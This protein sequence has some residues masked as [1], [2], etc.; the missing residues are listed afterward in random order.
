MNAAHPLPHPATGL[1]PAPAPV[2]VAAPVADLVPGPPFATP[3]V[4]SLTTLVH[5]FYA[6]VR[7]D[8]LLGPV[9]EA[10]L[11]DRWEPHLARMVDFWSTVALGSKRFRGNVMTKHMALSGVTPAHF[12]AWVKLWGEHTNRLFA[13]GVALE[14]QT[15]AHGIA[16]N[17]FQGYF[18][19]KPVFALPSAGPHAQAHPYARGGCSA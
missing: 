10:A 16:R 17:L 9:F 14:L 18:G 6:D 7:A 15:A 11:H 19:S 12:A 1:Q 8:A 2:E 4:Q 3:S 13:P 5:G